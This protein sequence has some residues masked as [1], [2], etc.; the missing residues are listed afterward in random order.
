MSLAL[1]ILKINTSFEDVKMILKWFFDIS[2][3][4]RFSE[5]SVEC[6]VHICSLSLD[7]NTISSNNTFS[8]FSVFLQLLLSSA[9]LRQNFTSSCYILRKIFAKVWWLPSRSTVP[10]N[11]VSKLPN[12]Q[13]QANKKHYQ[14]VRNDTSLKIIPKLDWI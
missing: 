2:T 7:W 5:I 8:L 12:L 4:F 14:M 11:K 13:Y 10:S 9:F 1:L 3:G 6:L